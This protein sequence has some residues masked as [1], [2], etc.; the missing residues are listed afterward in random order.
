MELA[1]SIKAHTRMSELKLLLQFGDPEQKKQALDALLVSALP[2]KQPA[3]VSP[4]AG[5]EANE[6]ENAFLET[7]AE[8][9]T[10][11]VPLG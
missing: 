7:H 3:T 1:A 9:G 8:D 5:T 11:I 4:A 2:S 6:Q 10:P